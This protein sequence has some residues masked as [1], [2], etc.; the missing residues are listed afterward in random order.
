MASGNI[1]LDIVIFH[2]HL[3]PGL[4]KTPNAIINIFDV[5]ICQVF[6]KGVV[7]LNV[8]VYL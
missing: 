5:F 2:A 7:Y 6:K 4:V 8:V 1:M 3:L